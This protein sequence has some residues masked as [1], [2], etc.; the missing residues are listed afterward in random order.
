MISVLAR[1]TAVSL[2]RNLPVLRGSAPVDHGGTYLSILKKRPKSR[3]VYISF[4]S[5]ASALKPHDMQTTVDEQ[6]L[7]LLCLALSTL[8]QVKL[9]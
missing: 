5:P 3:K 9:R 8:L 2:L 6:K 4:F 7:Y 1:I